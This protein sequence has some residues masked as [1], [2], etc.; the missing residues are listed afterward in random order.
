MG[1][2]PRGQ[3]GFRVASKNLRYREGVILLSRTAPFAGLPSASA[4]VEVELAPR[5]RPGPRPAGP[6]DAHTSDRAPAANPTLPQGCRP[7]ANPAAQAASGFG[8]AG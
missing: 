6:R 2:V 7:A 4:V 8:A 3:D 1:P 5:R